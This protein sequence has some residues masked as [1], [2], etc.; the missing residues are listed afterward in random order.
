L[1]SVPATAG[2][3]TGSREIHSVPEPATR[4]HFFAGGVALLVALLTRM[5]ASNRS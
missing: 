2:L 4:S 5:F 1:I 3:F